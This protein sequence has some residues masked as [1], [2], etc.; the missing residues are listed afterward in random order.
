M[1]GSIAFPSGGVGGGEGGGAGSL[2]EERN[3]E[4]SHERPGTVGVNLRVAFGQW[5]DASARWGGV[6]GALV[7]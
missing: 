1:V 7:G 3:R 5:R 6:P 4:G 2:D